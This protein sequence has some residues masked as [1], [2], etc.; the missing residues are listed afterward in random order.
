MTCRWQAATLGTAQWWQRIGEVGAVAAQ[1]V[2]D[3]KSPVSWDLPGWH[4]AT[5]GMAQWSQRIGDVDAV[6]AQ[7]MTNRRRRGNCRGGVLVGTSGTVGETGGRGVS[8]TGDDDAQVSADHIGLCTVVAAHRGQVGAVAAQG[9][10][11]HRR[12]GNCRGGVLVGTSGTVVGQVAEG[13]RA[14]GIVTCRWQP[15]TSGMVRW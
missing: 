2:E 11:N 8:S 9:M 12:R 14:S 5:L 4:A 7:G 10:A 15:A 13:W 1:A 3:D 6:A